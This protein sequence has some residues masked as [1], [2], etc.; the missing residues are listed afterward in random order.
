MNTE[1][2]H[3]ASAPD[4]PPLPCWSPY[5]AGF[6]LGIVLLLSF[7]VL[8]TGLGASGGIARVAAWLEHLVAPARTEASRY[9]GA[10]FGP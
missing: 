5:V 2:K 1:A 10:W 6:G 7:W 9:F 4:K 8:G 3:A